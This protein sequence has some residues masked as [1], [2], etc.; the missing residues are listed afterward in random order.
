MVV[1]N[2]AD[3]FLIQ[4]HCARENNNIYKARNVIFSISKKGSFAVKRVYV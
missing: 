4:V 3:I 1:D 2:L